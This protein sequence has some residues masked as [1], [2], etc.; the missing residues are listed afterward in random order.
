MPRRQL[1]Q[2]T[3][4]GRRASA[5]F[6]DV[7]GGRGG[8]LFYWH[9]RRCNKTHSKPGNRMPACA[10]QLSCHCQRDHCLSSIDLV[11]LTVNTCLLG[12]L[13]IFRET[14]IFVWNFPGN[15]RKRVNGYLQQNPSVLLLP[16]ELNAR[17]KKSTS[18]DSEERAK[19]C[20]LSTKQ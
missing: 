1:L 7:T 18:L 8:G 5:I 3:A 13:T 20:T 12:F 11:V 15:R 6:K 14:R 19:F 10:E 2:R 4:N 9:L 16:L 17:L